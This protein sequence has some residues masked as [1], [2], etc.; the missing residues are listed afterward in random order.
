MAGPGRK[1]DRGAGP[2]AAGRGQFF[3]LN[4]GDIVYIPRGFVHAAECGSEASLHITLG[5]H[6]WTWEDLLK[7]V[8]KATIEDD[9]RL[10]HA[11]PMGFMR[12]GVDGLVKDIATT[13]KNV[14]GDETRLA[15]MVERFNDELVTK[16]AL[17]IAGQVTSFFRPSQVSADR[18]GRPAPGHNLPAA[19]Q[20]RNCS[21]QLWRQDD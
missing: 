11:L 15:A 18:Q 12:G 2:G 10:T 9:Q 1:H 3:T 6:P 13:L 21:H 8:V 7:A 19:R 5:I 17:D 4:Q 14:A 16:S 20:W